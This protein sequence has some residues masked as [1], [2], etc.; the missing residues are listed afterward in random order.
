MANQELKISWQ[1]YVAIASRRKRWFFTPVILSII[2][3]VVYAVVA[4]RIYQA[5]TLIAVQDDK[6]INPLI[7]GLA[8]PREI[9]ERLNTLREELLAYSNLVKLVKHFKLDHDIEEGDQ[10][11]FE[12]R[13]AKFRDSL[14]VRMKGRTLIEVAYEG[15][16]PLTVQQIVNSLTE[17]VIDRNKIIATKE[18]GNAIHFIEKEMAVYRAKLEASEARL[19]EFKEIY[20]TQMPVAA[21]LNSRLQELEV[22]LANLLVENLPAHPRVVEVKRQIDEVRR[23]RDAEIQELV[24]KGVIDVED[25]A[26]MEQILEQTT[27]AVA[28]GFEA[29]EMTQQG[30]TQSISI[31]PDGRQLQISG[32]TPAT[33][34]LAPK[35]QQELSRLNRDYEVNAKIYQNLL[36]K[37]ETAMVTERLGSEE[38]GGKFEIIER[39]RL[40]VE[41][42]KPNLISVALIAIFSGIGVGIAFIIFA[43]Y[44]D[45]SVQTPD[46]L[47]DLLDLTSLGSISTIVTEAD[48]EMKKQQ[49]N[50]WFSLTGY[51]RGF[52]NYILQPIWSRIDR[53][54]V[55]WG[56]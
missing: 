5:S 33:V 53:L 38:D 19:R 14:A 31:S 18:T 40:P 12:R 3:G 42:I 54:L 24:A 46:E 47:A 17:I 1:D 7:E 29:P 35:Q 22:E 49:R 52:K 39:A 21:A 37:L 6:L 56:L 36:E 48:L 25:P 8:M 45:Q 30:A 23:Q 43:E 16:D 26:E 15:E 13:V 55:R 32:A 51:F 9:N 44:L 41:P 2:V 27:A 28:E 10:V 20:M 34:T 4:P 50:N 11:A